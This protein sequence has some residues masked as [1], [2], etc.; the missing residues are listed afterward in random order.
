[1]VVCT[2]S[3]TFVSAGRPCHFCGKDRIALGVLTLNGDEVFGAMSI[4]WCLSQVFLQGEEGVDICQ[5][6][7]V[8]LVDRQMQHPFYLIRVCGSSKAV[9]AP[10]LTPAAS[11]AS[12][13][14]HHDS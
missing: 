12:K 14:T 7:F 2:P 10:L 4:S 11:S 13:A 3:L 5:E 1:M 9:L 6:P 8:F